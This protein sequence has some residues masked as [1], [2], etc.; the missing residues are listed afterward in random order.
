MKCKGKGKTCN[1]DLKKK[2]K[3]HICGWRKEWLNSP[4]SQNSVHAKPHT[5]EIIKVSFKNDL[6]HLPHLHDL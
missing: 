4:W 3:N 2:K 5:S 6:S 1:H